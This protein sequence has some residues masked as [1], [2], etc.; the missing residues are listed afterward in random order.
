MSKPAII[1]APM[2]FALSFQLFS[3]VTVFPSFGNSQWGVLT[4][5]TKKV[6]D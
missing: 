4:D 2:S 6:K 5:E 1:P 3:F